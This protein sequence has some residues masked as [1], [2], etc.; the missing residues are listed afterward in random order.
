M[1]AIRLIAFMGLLSGLG[2]IGFATDLWNLSGQFADAITFAITIGVWIISVLLSVVNKLQ[3]LRGKQL[4]ILGFAPFVI[5]VVLLFIDA[6]F[7]HVW[8][9][10]MEYRHGLLMLV[11]YVADFASFTYIQGYNTFVE[12]DHHGH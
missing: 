4:P 3:L 8:A 2:F 10:P 12:T 9:G 11:F 7:I 5:A 1:R 6:L